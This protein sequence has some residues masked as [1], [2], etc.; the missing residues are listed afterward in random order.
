MKK[1]KLIIFFIVIA[2]VSAFNIYPQ[3]YSLGLKRTPAELLRTFRRSRVSVAG[4]TVELPASYSLMSKMPPVRSQGQQGSCVGWSIGYFVKSYQ[5]NMERNWGYGD[6]GRLFSPAFIYNQINDGVDQGSSIV[7]ALELLKQRGCSTLNTMNY[8]ENDYRSRPDNTA[9]ME[10]QRFKASG[11][12]SIT[13]A[14]PYEIKSMLY[15]GNPVIVGLDVYDNFQ[16][17]RSGVLRGKT[18]VNR[19][20]HAI[21]V[22]GY[23]DTKNAFQLVNSWGTGWGERGI[24]WVDYQTFAEI[25]FEAWVL[26][27]IV[28][29]NIT[30]QQN[31]PEEV[32]AT[33]G[34]HPNQIVIKWN[35]VRETEQYIIFRKTDNQ[36]L[37]DEIARTDRN[38]Y[39]DTSVVSGVVYYYTIKATGTNG[40]SDFSLVDTGYT[41]EVS[42]TNSPYAPEYV[43][44]TS[45]NGNV[46]IEWQQVIIAQTYKIYRWDETTETW[47]TIGTTRDMKFTDT[48]G[49]AGSSYWYSVAAGNSNGYSRGSNPISVTVQSASEVPAVPTGLTVSQGSYTDRI[50]IG[51]D[52]VPNA[53]TYHIY[54]WYD[55][56]NDWEFVAVTEQ[57][58]YADQNVRR[59]VTYFYVVCAGNGSGYSGYCSHESGST[60]P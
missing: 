55:G 29:Q 20:G 43:W 33:D 17:Y 38:E 31:A 21:A 28:E 10:A 59:G 24:G 47:V 14:N 53:D 1:T 36:N 2:G 42:Q 30:G 34:L 3:N 22:V 32:T 25:V 45:S 23:D 15:D 26:Y 5:E 35:S 9:I 46:I 57:I 6:N 44:G 39:I 37:Y 12:A 16:N 48:T 58:N 52:R 56:L 11:Y 40:T 7:D 41:R 50:V 4:T 13:Y 51:W 18:G 8:R 19:G 49:R 27:D 60:R 54:R